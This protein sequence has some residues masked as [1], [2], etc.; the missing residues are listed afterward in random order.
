M[1]DSNLYSDNI[2]TALL[3]TAAVSNKTRQVLIERIEEKDS[4]PL[5]FSTHHF[6]LL[7]T[8]CDILMAQNSSERICN[9]AQAI[10]KR[11]S[12]DKSDGWRYDKMPNDKLAFTNGLNAVDEFAIAL[13]E[14]PFLSIT[15]KQQVALLEKIKAGET[16]RNCWKNL[17]PELFFEELLAE[18]TAIFYSHPLVQQEIG[19]VGMADVNGWQNIGLNSKDPIEL[20]EIILNK[21]Y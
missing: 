2:V 13:F 18:V 14:I 9:P 16:Q 4:P 10:D 15:Y 11:L 12:E 5:F 17:S 6:N 20:D 19:F 8:L 1:T 21:K 7:T 3:N